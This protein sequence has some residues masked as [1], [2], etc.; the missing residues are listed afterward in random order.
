MIKYLER[1]YDVLAANV[2]KNLDG[3]RI[4]SITKTIYIGIS[5][6]IY[7][8]LLWKSKAVEVLQKQYV[9]KVLLSVNDFNCQQ[10]LAYFKNISEM[11]M[12]CLAASA[13]KNEAEV[14]EK[15]VVT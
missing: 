2:K 15:T 6:F 5:I 1:N 4:W 11:L 13:N 10:C 12:K 8:L 7:A 14:I 9:A 3:L